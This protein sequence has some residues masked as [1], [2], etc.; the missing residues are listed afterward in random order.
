MASP[1]K[2]LDKYSD[3]QKILQKELPINAARLKCIVLLVVALLKV[4]SVS[5]ERLSQGFENEVELS[6]NVRRIKRFFAHFDLC[7]NM[8]ARLLFKLLPISGPFKLSL[9]RTNWKFGTTHINILVLGVIHKGVSIPILWTFLTNKSG[10]SDQKTRIELLQ[11]YVSLFGEDSIEWLT[12]DREFI[13]K[14]WLQFLIDH[15]IRFFIRIRENME[16]FTSQK[17]TVRAFWFFNSMGFNNPYFYPKIV[18]L[19]G[20]WVY[21]SGM[22][23]I[24]DQGKIEFL[25]VASYQK[26]GNAL[27][28]YKDRWQIETMFKAFKTAGFH[29]EE[30]HLV[31]YQRLNRLLMI[32]ALAFLWS[33]KVGIY[34]NQHVRPIEIKKHGRAD[35]S[36]FAYGL[37]AL[38]QAFLNGYAPRIALYV[39]IFA[40]EL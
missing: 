2:K 38:A 34:R 40:M 28:Y 3:L 12:A 33:Y 5:L 15:R 22:K 8:I 23:F 10:N 4:Q 37:E 16:V 7:G 26:T 29:L 6:S 19:K 14:I 27:I 18:R 21:L 39:T 25:I 35:K 30:T 24:N 32:V 31:D 9:D 13:G 11:R 20:C 17:G 36:L 1:V